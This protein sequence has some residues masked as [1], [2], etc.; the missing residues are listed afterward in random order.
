MK[1]V[2][3]ISGGIILAVFILVGG[4]LALTTGALNYTKHKTEEAMFEKIEF[5]CAALYTNARVEA[6]RRRRCD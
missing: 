1:L 2:L 6:E 3:Q 5:D 4:G